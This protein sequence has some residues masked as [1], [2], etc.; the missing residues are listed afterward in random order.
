LGV[1]GIC[2]VDSM[3]GMVPRNWIIEFYGDENTVNPVLHYVTAYRSRFGRVLV[4]LNKDFGG[5]DPYTVTRLARILGGDSL[6]IDVGRGFRFS[7]TI[8]MLGEAGG[9]EGY[10]SVMLVYPYY[11]MPRGLKGYSLATRVT[12]LARELAVNG[13]RVFLFNTVSRM[14]GWMPEGGHY[15]HHSVHVIVRV[16]RLR[17]GRI[18]VRL[19]KHPS[20]PSGGLASFKLE[21][22]IGGVAAQRPLTAWL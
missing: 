7:D 3:I 14:G 13:H 10:D 2:V 1:T 19:V 12:G 4:L 6:R 17:N 22:V 16:D 20:R 8:E 5:L 9:M 18:G 11:H 15:H 21:G